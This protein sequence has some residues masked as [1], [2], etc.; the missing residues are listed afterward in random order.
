MNIG[1]AAAASGVSAKMIRH[2][3]STGVLVSAKRSQSGYRIYNDN[4]VHVL[5]FIKRARSL[6]FPVAEIRKLLMLWRSRRPSAEVKRL[7]LGHVSELEKKII[8]MQ[9]MASTLSHLAQHC[10][11]D[12]RPECPILEALGSGDV[13]P[14]W[15]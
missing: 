5:R 9:E 14:A 12:E 3:E 15:R 6:G 1:Q 13:D 7:A 10:H 4:D 8:E 11:G 2:Y